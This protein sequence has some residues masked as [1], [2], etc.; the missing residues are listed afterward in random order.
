[1]VKTFLNG[2]QL[3]VNPFDD[4]TLTMQGN[5]QQIEIIDVGDITKIGNRKLTSLSI[6]SLFSANVYPFSAISNPRE[7]AYYIGLITGCMEDKKPVR[8]V[9]VGDGVD[10]NLRCSVEDFKTT[11]AAGETNECYYTLSLREYREP[12]VRRVDI[13]PDELTRPKAKVQSARAEQPPSVRTHTAKYGDTLWGMAKTY[14]GNGALYMKIYNANKSVTPDPN[15]I[16]PGW[17]FVI[18]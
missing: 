7:P 12:V 4:I 14:Y 2:V 6:S 1:M 8:L 9:I 15:T 10:V 11:R 18:P 3:P 16:Y 13:I 5:N 17:V